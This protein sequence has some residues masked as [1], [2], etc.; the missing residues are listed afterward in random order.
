VP[1]PYA[2]LLRVPGGPAFSA[3]A[4]VGRLPISMGGIGVVLLVSAT[5]HRYGLAGAVA[6]VTALAEAVGQPLLSRYVDRHGQSRAVPPMVV[7]CA[8]GLAL[9]TW[10]ATSGQPA[11]TLFAAGLLAGAAWPNLGALVRARWSHALGGGPDLQTAYSLESVL[12]EVIFVLGPPLVTWVA[13]AVGP[14]QAMATMAG[15][16]VVGCALFLVQRRTEPPRLPPGSPV[17]RSS[18]SVPGVRVLVVIM[19][20]LGGVFGSFEVVTVAFTEQQGHQAAAGVVLALNAAGSMVAGLAYGAL[21]PTSAVARQLLVLTLLVP[22]TVI[23]FP[24]AGSIP[25]LCVLAFVAGFVI[26]PALIATFRLVERLAPAGRLTEGLTLASTGIVLGV[27]VAA[28]V[29]GRVIDA[30]GTPQAYLVTTV[31]GVLTAVA[32]LA[33]ARTLHAGTAASATPVAPA[34]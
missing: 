19:V 24:F 9:M 14:P 31:S 21:R 32:G 22:L 4:F 7:A 15:L 6:A 27:A 30:F 26:S 20:A 33:G 16:L 28:A 3:A 2:A 1:N 18:L 34:A 29:S 5:T 17:G 12:D 11:W 8:L 10:C 23:G 13:V 25:V